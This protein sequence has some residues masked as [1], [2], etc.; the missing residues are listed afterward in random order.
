[1]HVYE[2]HK[3]IKVAQFSLLPHILIDAVIIIRGILEFCGFSRDLKKIIF[4]V[5]INFRGLKKIIT[6]VETN[7]RGLKKNITLVDM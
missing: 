6:F 4:F 7:F 5:E 3:Q 1:M 2:N